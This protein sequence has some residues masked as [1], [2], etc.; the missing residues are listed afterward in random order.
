MR[1]SLRIIYATIFALIVAITFMLA[2]RAGID[3]R[4]IDAIEKRL[5]IEGKK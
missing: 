5:G 3:T 2:V 4:R 1:D